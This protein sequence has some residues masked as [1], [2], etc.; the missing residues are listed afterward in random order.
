MLTTII[1][2][3]GREV[4]FDAEKITGAITRAFLAT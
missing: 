4:P 2:R 3:D 1:K